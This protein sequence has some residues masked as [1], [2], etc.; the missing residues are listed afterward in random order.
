MKPI[1]EISP[2][3]FRRV[4]EVDLVG[5]YL[6]MRKVV[7]LMRAQEPNPL[8][9]SVVNVSSIQGKEGMQMAAAYSAAKAGMISLTKTVAKETAKD[10]IVVTCITPAAVETNMAKELRAA[11]RADILARI[12]MGRFV[13]VDEV[14]RMVLWLAA[15]EVSFSSGGIFDISGGRATY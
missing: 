2:E 13:E 4:I 12:P 8:R 11:R 1:W 7:G 6:M 15:G 3:D 9:G 5:A 10:N 14:S